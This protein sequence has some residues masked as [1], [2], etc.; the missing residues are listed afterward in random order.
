MAL[1]VHDFGGGPQPEPPTPTAHDWWA[2]LAL[3][4]LLALLFL[5]APLLSAHA[6]AQV[7]T[8]KVEAGITEGTPWP[9]ELDGDPQTREWLNLGVRDAVMQYQVIVLRE[10]RFCA[11]AWRNPWDDVP[12]W[13]D[14]VWA[15]VLLEVHGRT[16]FV[17]NSPQYYLEI[18]F[19]LP[20]CGG[21]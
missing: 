1:I 5:I 13:I 16:Q 3:A 17:V 15:G 18:P 19:T 12:T 10:G 4:I 14:G 6:D 9:Y 20:A 7:I 21:R 8:R 11:G 2:G